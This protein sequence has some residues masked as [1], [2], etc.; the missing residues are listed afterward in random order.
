LTPVVIFCGGRGL[1]LHPLTEKRPK[2]LLP[3]GDKAILELIIE[4]YGRQGFKKFWLAV[5]YKADLIKE[6]FGDGSSRGLKIKYL[7]EDRPLGTGGALNMLPVFKVPFIITNADVLV[8]P[9]LSYGHLMEFHAR[10]ECLA[11]VC[12][13][14]HQQQVPFGVV[15]HE[16]GRLIAIRE[17]P[18][19]N[20]S[21][22]AGLY[23]LEPDALQY[24]PPGRFDLP[25]LIANLPK[26]GV[27]A[28]AAV[29]PI[30]GHWQDIGHFENLA[31][32]M[33][34]RMT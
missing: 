2:P 22:N 11:T 5:N 33:A 30:R 23:V 32:V 9:P 7:E 19:E 15:D 6:Y 13:G 21:V 18:I 26:E 3:V 14:L 31:K 4:E 10:A 16:E 17:K 20:F 8:T 12:M 1:R 24:A 27:R 28:G 25:D 34:A 29:Y